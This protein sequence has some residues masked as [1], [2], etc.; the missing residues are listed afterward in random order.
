MLPVPHG[1]HPALAP[2]SLFGENDGERRHDD[3]GDEDLAGEREEHFARFDGVVGLDEEGGGG[4][5][6]AMGAER[7]S[8]AICV[9]GCAGAAEDP[10]GSPENF[11]LGGFGAAQFL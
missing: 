8:S 9:V 2:E 4:G 10:G 7:A 3:E 11:P 1:G 5:G 6:A